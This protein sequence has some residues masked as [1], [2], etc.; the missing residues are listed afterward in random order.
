[1]IFIG[2][3]LL[4]AAGL[5]LLISAD[6][7]SFVGLTQQQTG[8]LVPLLVILI[9]IAGGLFTRRRRFAELFGGLV[10]WMGIF[11]VAIVGYTLRDDIQNLAGRVFGELAPGIAVVD[12]QNGTATFRRGMGGHFQVRASING[13]DIPLIFDTGASAVVLTAEDARKAGIDTDS[14]RYTVS[15]STANG[16]GKAASVKLGHMNVGGIERE[17]VRAFVA[18]EHA[19]DTSLLGMTFLETLTRYAVSSNSLELVN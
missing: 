5:A 12:S 16:M 7:G 11:G 9:V 6:A 8:Q 18:E 17:G 2:V 1:M 14:L 19:L 4:V 13:A 15:V 10:L 3:A